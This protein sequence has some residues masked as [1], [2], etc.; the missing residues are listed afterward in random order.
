[1]SV[2][3]PLDAAAAVME[4]PDVADPDQLTIDELTAQS[5]VPSRTIR[6]YQSKGVLPPPEIKGRVAYYGPAH[7]ERL[8]LIAK[9]QDRG[10]RIDA[11]RALLAR[12]DRNELDVGE[13]LGLDAQLKASWANDQ[14]RAVSEAELLELAGSDRVGLIADLVRLR[15]VERKGDTYLVRSPALLRVAMRLEGAGIDLETAIESETILRKNLGRAAR[16]V[17]KYFFARAQD[18]HVRPPPDGDW[19][20]VFEELRHTSI[21]AVRVVFGQEMER[22]LR[23]FIEDGATAK[24]PTR[25]RRRR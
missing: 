16:E 23:E 14:P 22:V 25:H 7:L 8:A 13:W 20:R 3:L 12:I 9:L 4:G 10:L 6:Y 11:I 19:A 18:S 5:R 2:A 1:M 15:A 17:A 21:E 24:L